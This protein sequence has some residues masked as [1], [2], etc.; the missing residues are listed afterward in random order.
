MTRHVIAALCGF[1]IANANAAET[2]D[3]K[4]SATLTVSIA[5]IDCPLPVYA[6]RFPY[7]AVAFNAR[8]NEY[9]FG[10]YRKFDE[11]IIEIQ[12]AGGDTSGLPANCFLIPWAKEEFKGDM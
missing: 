8:T 5:K 11:N 12:W 3:C 2:L 4:L 1:F 7:G 9:L 6:D 10:C